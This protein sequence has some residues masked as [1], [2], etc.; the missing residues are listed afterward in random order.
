MP[1][2]S[3]IRSAEADHPGQLAEL[4]VLRAENAVRRQ[5]TRSPGTLGTGTRGHVA[6]KPY[7]GDLAFVKGVLQGG[8]QH[9][10]E[11]YGRNGHLVVAAAIVEKADRTGLLEIARAELVR[12]AGRGDGPGT[13]QLLRWAS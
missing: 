12:R 6:R 11:L 8:R 3:V 4:A 9:P 2:K 13:E 10:C 5:R 1:Q 7:H